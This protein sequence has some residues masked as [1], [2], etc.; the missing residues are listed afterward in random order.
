MPCEAKDLRLGDRIIA[1]EHD[2]KTEVLWTVELDATTDEG[3]RGFNL[4]AVQAFVRM[5]AAEAGG[6]KLYRIPGC[7]CIPGARGC[8][9]LFKPQALAPLQFKFDPEEI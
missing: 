5:K 3:L 7:R 8:S 2:G 1:V 6:A 9:S 4:N